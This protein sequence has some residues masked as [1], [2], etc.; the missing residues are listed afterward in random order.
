MTGYQV[1]DPDWAADLV[2]GSFEKAKTLGD[3]IN[4]VGEFFGEEAAEDL[5]KEMR[6]IV[7]KAMLRKVE[8][9][10][11]HWEGKTRIVP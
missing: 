4:D 7:G 11:P 2:V 5:R 9:N 1:P 8:R 3:K 10:N 6:R